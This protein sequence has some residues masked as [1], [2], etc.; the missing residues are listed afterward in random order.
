MPQTRRR[1]EN[2]MPSTPA[3]HSINEYKKP[4]GKRVHHNNSACPP[5]RDIPQNERR[6]STGGNRLC[7]DCKRLNNERK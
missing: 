5:G 4:E 6:P 2:N 7:E 3:F 1:K